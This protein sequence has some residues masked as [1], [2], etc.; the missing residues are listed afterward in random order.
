LSIRK[1]DVMSGAALA[2]PSDA[3]PTSQPASAQRLDGVDILR[4]LSILAVVILHVNIRIALDKTPLGPFLASAVGSALDL[5]RILVWNGFNGVVIFFAVSGFLIT[6]NCLRRWGSLRDISLPGFYRLR[7]ARIAPLL[8]A[9]LAVS[10]A[11]HFAHVQGFTIDTAK[12]SWARTMVAA[13]T[14]HMNWLEAHFGYPPANL[15]VLWSLS[16]E[17]VFYLGFPLACLL[18][19]G[20]RGLVVFLLTF[21]ALGP[22]A[23][24]L[25]TQNEMWADHSYLSCMDAIALGCLAAMAAKRF[26]LAPRWL[27]GLRGAGLSL[28]VLV[29]CCRP[30]CRRFGIFQHGLDVTLLAL[31]TALVLVA[32]AQGSQAGGRLTA[33][34]RWFGRNSYEIYLTHS[35]VAVLGAQ[36]FVA[37]GNPFGWGLLWFLGVTALSGAI[38]AAVA[39]Y[40]S[41]PLNRRLRAAGAG[42]LVA[43]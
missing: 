2:I 20:G 1:N 43:G 34:L 37:L 30:L 40:F 16:V 32:I 27:L 5:K 42:S 33:P 38:G 14:F 15:D 3:A 6:S 18:L 12:V 21:V 22:F 29:T 11:L 36:I 19:R 39:K 23:R 41:E 31:G 26:P 8:V 28:M 10:S 35:F 25:F 4:G 9:L 7:F 24:T 17:E 13:L